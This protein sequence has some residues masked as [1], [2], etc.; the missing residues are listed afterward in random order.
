[1]NAGLWM[2]AAV[3]ED[4]FRNGAVNALDGM[5]Q[6]ARKTK[7]DLAISCLS[8]RYSIHTLQKTQQAIER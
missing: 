8:R 3:E 7:L 2:K 6:L 5:V 1:M 4:T